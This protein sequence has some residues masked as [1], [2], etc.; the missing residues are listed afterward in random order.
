MIFSVITSEIFNYKRF[1]TVYELV[2]K[3][4]K[5]V[6]IYMYDI[7]AVVPDVHLPLSIIEESK[8]HME[9]SIRS[10]TMFH[11]E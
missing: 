9:M 4:V 5:E 8:R 2:N 1:L 11:F 6:E 3:R 10:S 7:S